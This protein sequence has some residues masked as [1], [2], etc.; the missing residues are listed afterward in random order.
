MTARHF[1]TLA[2]AGL[3]AG[4]VL[5]VLFTCSAAASA[6]SGDPVSHSTHPLA[7]E[8]YQIAFLLAIA[9]VVGAHVGQNLTV[10]LRDIRRELRRLGRPGNDPLS[11]TREDSK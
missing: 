9:I 2:G 7:V 11:S 1:A 6:L 8:I 10:A 5:G 3:A 4:L